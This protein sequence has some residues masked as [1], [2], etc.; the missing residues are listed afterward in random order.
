MTNR[1]PLAVFALAACAA[2]LGLAAC[3][4]GKESPET[5]K[6]NLCTSLNNLAGTVVDLQGMSP[7]TSSKDDYTAATDK[8]KDA[9]N[10]VATDAKDLKNAETGQLGSAYDDLQ[11][12]VQNLPTDVP[13]VEAVKSLGP[14]L[15][16][17]A[18][19]WSSTVNGLGCK[20]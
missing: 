5:A 17:L 4:G 1:A 18:S 2:V 8:I 10:D 9:W 6:A 11:D 3:G 19:A 20:S 7:L 15:A 13:L 16:A 14:D 12:S